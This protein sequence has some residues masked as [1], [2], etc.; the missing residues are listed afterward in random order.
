VTGLV[1]LE[2]ASSGDSGEDLLKLCR[3]RH[4]GGRASSVAMARL[5]TS[6]SFGSGCWG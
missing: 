5:P 2:V 4:G 6:T 1:D 3:R